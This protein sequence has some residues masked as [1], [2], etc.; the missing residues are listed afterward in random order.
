MWGRIWDMDGTWYIWIDMGPYGLIW[1]RMEFPGRHFRVPDEDSF[2]FMRISLIFRTIL[3]NETLR[4][5]QGLYEAEDP[6][7]PSPLKLQGPG[8]PS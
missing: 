6:P 2:T 8:M 3:R 1:D 5:P 7:F 4:Y